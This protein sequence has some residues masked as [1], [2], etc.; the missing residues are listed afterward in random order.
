MKPKAALRRAAIPLLGEERMM[1]TLK[2]AKTPPSVN[3]LWANVGKRRIKTAAYQAWATAA[4]WE[5]KPQGAWHCA[6][7]VAIA[8]TINPKMTKCDLDNMIKPVLDLLVN[9]GRISDDR[10]VV[11]V[12]ARFE[13]LD[14]GTK[15]VIAKR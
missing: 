12:S 1:G 11:D 13:G 9:A 4:H 14:C 8:L 5:I 3:A 7:H 10:M 15:I 6:G 2:L